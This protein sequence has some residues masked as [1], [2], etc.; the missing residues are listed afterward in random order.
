L[1]P[2]GVVAAAS[3]LLLLLK[4]Q[5]PEYEQQRQDAMARASSMQLS[6]LVQ[7]SSDQPRRTCALNQLSGHVSWAI[8]LILS[9]KLFLQQLFAC[10]LEF[11]IHQA[12]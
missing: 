11:V 6:L 1:I 3:F 8:T 7:E 2:R 10:F 12:K 9:K 5:S 4:A